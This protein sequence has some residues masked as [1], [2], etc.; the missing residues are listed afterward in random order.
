[1]TEAFNNRYVVTFLLHKVEKQNG[2][3]S[4]QAEMNK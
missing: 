2:N 1:M 4:V 3:D